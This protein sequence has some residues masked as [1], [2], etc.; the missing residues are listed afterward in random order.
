MRPRAKKRSKYK[1]EKT[2]VDGIKFDSKGESRRYTAL[3]FLER[4]GKISRL[5]LQPEFVLQ[6]GFRR[7]GKRYVAIK[8]KADF[9]YL[10]RGKVVIEDYKGA[11]TEGFKMKKKMFL[12][13]HN[14]EV[15]RI[16]SRR[17]EVDL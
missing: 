6:E 9:R 16:S 12:L 3:K 4:A 13:L 7:N 5:E 14:P 8:Y 15:Y 17:G 1:S 11:E 10:E 2:T